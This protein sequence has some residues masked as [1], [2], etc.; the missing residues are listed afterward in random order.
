MG[1]ETPLPCFLLGLGKQWSVLGTVS[2]AHSLLLYNTV[3]S[4]GLSFGLG[5]SPFLFRAGDGVVVVGYKHNQ[6]ELSMPQPASRSCFH[7]G[8]EFL[9][10]CD[11]AGQP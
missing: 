2:M 8:V 10:E 9:G 11:L 6:L 3:L 7:P 4:P 5:L 1:L